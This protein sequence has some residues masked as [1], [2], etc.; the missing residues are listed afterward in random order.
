M[1]R[2][3]PRTPANSSTTKLEGS[4][5][6]RERSAMGA[7]QT[8]TSV[9][10]A[11]IPQKGSGDDTVEDVNCLTRRKR[12]KPPRL[13][14]VPGSLGTCPRKQ[15]VQSTRLGSVPSGAF[16]VTFH[17]PQEQPGAIEACQS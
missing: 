12:P 6:P 11:N 17:S 9:I 13:V 5:F 10:S 8:L 14:M 4:F 15:T 3:A 2:S 16:T 1:N 7:S